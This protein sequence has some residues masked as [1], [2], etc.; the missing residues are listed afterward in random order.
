[1]LHSALHSPSSQGGIFLTVAN[2]TK[3]WEVTSV[4]TVAEGMLGCNFRIKVGLV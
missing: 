4:Q 2:G 1:M 3:H